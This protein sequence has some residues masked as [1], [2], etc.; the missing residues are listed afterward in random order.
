MGQPDIGTDPKIGHSTVKFPI[1][2]Q[3]SQS[4]RPPRS[5]FPSQVRL[6]RF[7]QIPEA[8]P[9]WSGDHELRDQ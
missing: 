6:A 7:L 8:S 5:L 9:E 4:K 3:I 2:W 1:S